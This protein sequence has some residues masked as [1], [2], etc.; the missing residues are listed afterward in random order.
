MVDET[1]PYA[2]L[3]S[4]ELRARVRAALEADPGSDEWKRVSAERTQAAGDKADRI[5]KIQEEMRSG[6]RRRLRL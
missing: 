1:K 2:S 6:T 4:P 5:S 3:F